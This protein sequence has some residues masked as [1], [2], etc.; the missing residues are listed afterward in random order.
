MTRLLPL[1][2]VV[3]LAACTP[4]ATATKAG[5]SSGPPPTTG[6]SPSRTTGTE[7]RWTTDISVRHDPAVPPVPIL[8]EVRTGDHAAE[9]Y[10]RITFAFRGPLPSYTVRIVRN[11]VRDGSGEPVDLPGATLLSVVFTPAG[12]HTTAGRHDVGYRRLLAYERTGDYEG[13]VSYGLGV[14]GTTTIRTGESTRPDGTNVVALDI[15]L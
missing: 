12:S 4:E 7:D 11:V 10:E 3:L 1:A 2:L 9:G 8:V 13:Y 6:T 5:R 14:Q 15:K